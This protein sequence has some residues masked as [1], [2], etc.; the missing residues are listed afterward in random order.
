VLSVKVPDLKFVADQGQAGV[1]GMP[2]GRERA[3]RGAGQPEENPTEAKVIAGKVIHA[4]AAREAAR[5]A[6]VDPKNPLEWL[7][8]PA[9]RQ[10]QEKDP[11]KSELFIVEGDSGGSAKMG[12]NRDR[13]PVARQD[14]NVERPHGQDAVLGEIGTLIPRSARHQRDLGSV[15]SCATAKIIVMTDADVDGR[16]RTLLLTSSTGRCASH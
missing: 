8:C 7:R 11:A 5:K 6:R 15:D 1:L 10:C 4:A 16:I 12:R 3:H 9:A 2:G 14:L 13:K